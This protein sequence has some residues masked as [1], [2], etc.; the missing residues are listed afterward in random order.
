MSLGLATGIPQISGTIAE[1]T[2]H[3]YQS[4]SQEMAEGADIN[5]ALIL[6][7]SNIIKLVMAQ[8]LA[9]KQTVDAATMEAEGGQMI[10]HCIVSLI[11]T[12]KTTPAT[13]DWEDLL[14]NLQEKINVQLVRVAAVRSSF[15]GILAGL[16]EVRSPPFAQIQPPSSCILVDFWRADV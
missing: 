9:F 3:F 1:L 4:R 5:T 10:A 15:E 2:T 11:K 8:G 13:D 12:I 7:L 14:K 6:Q 16:R